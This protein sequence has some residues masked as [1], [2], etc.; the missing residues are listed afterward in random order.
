MAYLRQLENKY[1]LMDE[2]SVVEGRPSDELSRGE[3]NIP[4]CK[5][6][7]VCDN[8]ELTAFEIWIKCC[9]HRALGIISPT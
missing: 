8:V 3:F 5:L 2:L 4:G 6:D 9:G 7:F 1:S